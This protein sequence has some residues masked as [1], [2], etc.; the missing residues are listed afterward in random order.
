[1]LLL[2]QLKMNELPEL[3]ARKIYKYK[4]EYVFIDIVNK[5]HKLL[6]AY[7]SYFKNLNV[8]NHHNGIPKNIDDRLYVFSFNMFP[9]NYEPSGGINWERLENINLEFWNS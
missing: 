2:L 4:L 9:E 7:K 6:E 5:N 8:Y 1:L 3:V